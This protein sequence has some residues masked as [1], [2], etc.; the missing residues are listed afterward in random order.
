MTVYM[1]Y[2]IATPQRLTQEQKRNWFG[3]HEAHKNNIKKKKRTRDLVECESK[4]TT[5]S[6]LWDS[7]GLCHQSKLPQLIFDATQCCHKKFSTKNTRKN[8]SKNQL[9]C[10]DPQSLEFYLQYTKTRRVSYTLLDFKIPH[11]SQKEW[12]AVPQH[13]NGTKSNRIGCD[14]NPHYCTYNAPKK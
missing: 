8:L 7:W 3:A 9:K 10:I 14:I 4:A 6:P 1:L 2:S 13:L 5:V 11:E 12:N